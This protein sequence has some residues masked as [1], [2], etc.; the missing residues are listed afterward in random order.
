M[1][2]ANESTLLDIPQVARMEEARQAQGVASVADIAEP[3]AGGFMCFAG[4]GSW[5]NQAMGLGMNGPVSD[6]D[7]ERLIDFYQVR[8]VEPRIEV[9]PHADT[10]LVRGLA[11]RG[12]VVREFK[13]VLVRDLGAPLPAPP[14]GIDVEVVDPADQRRVEEHV[15]IKAAG[16]AVADVPLF[17]RLARRSLAGGG[18]VRGFTASIA[19]QAVAAG[20]I[21][22]VPPCAAL[23]GMTTL[24]SHRRRG[25]QLALLIARLRAAAEAG[26][27]FATIQSE[28]HIGT[29]RNALR[30]GFVIIY[31]K[32]TLV[33]PGPG[34]APSP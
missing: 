24:P 5:A 10:S 18:G 16:F 14:E 17:S 26:C 7:L 19:G 13:N 25:C 32:V 4:V 31:T 12:F 30:L 21:D 20:A 28:P 23:F 6:A 2:N 27:R 8:G 34:L 11:D 9:C 15:A 29:A 33:R 3:V 22:I 1:S